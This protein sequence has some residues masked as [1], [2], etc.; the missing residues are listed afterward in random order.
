VTLTVAQARG[1]LLDLSGVGSQGRPSPAALF[2]T[3]RAV[4]AEV[5]G[6]GGLD[7]LDEI[8]RLAADVPASEWPRLLLVVCRLVL[9]RASGAANDA[10]ELLRLVLAV[11]EV[12]R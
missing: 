4:A 2:T 7:Q 5:L 11:D 3:G 8:E 12:G 6:T 10:A 9:A 1:E